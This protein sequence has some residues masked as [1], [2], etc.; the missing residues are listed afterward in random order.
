[1]SR[2]DIADAAMPEG[3]DD[4]LDDVEQADSRFQILDRSMIWTDAGISILCQ[5]NTDGDGSWSY[6]ALRWF[7]GRM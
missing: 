2:N 5:H 4:L 3:A 1:M 6:A 7:L